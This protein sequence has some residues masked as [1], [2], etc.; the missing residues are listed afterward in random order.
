MRMPLLKG[1]PGNR[2]AASIQ[3]TV[4]YL[5]R[6]STDPWGTG[7]LLERRTMHDHE[8]VHQHESKHQAPGFHGDGE[9]EVIPGRKWHKDW[10]VWAVVL[11]LLAAMTAYVLTLGGFRAI[12]GSPAAMAPVSQTAP[13]G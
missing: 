11:L 3:G 7:F 4:R 5:S 8:K 10:R 9:R 13:P 1:S 12:T 6:S 2:R